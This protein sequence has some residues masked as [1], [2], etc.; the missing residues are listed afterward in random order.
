MASKPLGGPPKNNWGI[1]GATGVLTGLGH[2]FTAFAVSALLNPIA[3]ELGL[4]RAVVSAAI[5]GGRM[6]AGLTAPVAGWASDRFSPRGVVALGMLITSAGLALTSQA[7]DEWGL[8]LAWSLVVSLGVATAFTVSLDKIVVTVTKTGR[9]LALAIR[10]SI[11]GLVTT[12]VMPV[13]GWMV[14]QHGWRFVCI[15]WALLL[16]A[17]VP[18]PL[19]LFPSRR[20]AGN[21]PA[22]AEPIGAAAPAERSA[23]S[24]G[25]GRSSEFRAAL[26]TS[27]FWIIALAF[28]LQAAANT[29]MVVHLVPLMTDGGMSAGMAAS[30]AGAAVLVSIPVR[31]STGW[32]ADRLQTSHLV[33]L[34]GGIMLSE[35]AV[36]GAYALAPGTAT[37]LLLLLSLGIATGA[38]TLLVLVLVVRIFGER[39]YG[40]VQGSLMMMQIPGTLLAPVLAGW[41]FD[42][43][44]NYIPAVAGFAVALFFGGAALFLLRAPNSS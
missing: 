25:L 9:G 4:G 18:I 12:G 1:V 31:L 30:V 26:A 37:L 43:L 24:F 34:L 5:G 39:S 17:L 16:L 42:A 21:T 36:N 44:G 19:L 40:T 23:P 41:S 15:A 11:A 33:M 3:T 8:Y 20:T 29:G 38:P 13:V 14:S 35:A 28:M 6:V 22:A 27:A 2:G 32:I 10:F 7:G